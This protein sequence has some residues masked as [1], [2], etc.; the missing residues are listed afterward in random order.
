MRAFIKVWGNEYP[1]RVIVWNENHSIFNVTF[2]DENDNRYTVFNRSNRKIECNLEKNKG[3]T[4]VILTAD[5]DEIVYLKEKT[6][7]RH[8][9]F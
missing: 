1:V 3:N 9:E 4:D 7:R 5:L 6:H 8:D 2:I